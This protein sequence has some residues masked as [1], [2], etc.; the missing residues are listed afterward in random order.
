MGRTFGEYMAARR[1]TITLED[2]TEVVLRRP[3][4][5][6]LTQFGP[7]PGV[8]EVGNQVR[9]VEIA[10]RLITACVIQLGDEVDPI[11]RGLMTFE[12][13]TREEVDVIVD[14]VTKFVSKGADDAGVPL[15]GTDSPTGQQHS[16]TVSDSVTTV[17]LQPS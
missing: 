13:F 10:R 3:S 15:D 6:L 2:G 9:Q 1:R 16:S 11:G 7:V 8:E 17:D 14:G 12:D 5:A 4:Y